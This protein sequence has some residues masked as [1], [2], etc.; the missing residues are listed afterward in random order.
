MAYIKPQIPFLMSESLISNVKIDELKRICEENIAY[1]DEKMQL[2]HNKCINNIVSMIERKSGRAIC[3]I[4]PSV[5]NKLLPIMEYIIYL[6]LDCMHIGT[7][8]PNIRNHNLVKVKNMDV[9]MK[10]VSGDAAEKTDSDEQFDRIRKRMI[11]PVSKF[12]KRI[13]DQTCELEYVLPCDKPQKMVIDFSKLS[14]DDRYDFSEEY[15]Y[16]GLPVMK[17]DNCI[18]METIFD[19]YDHLCEQF[20]AVMDKICK[21]IKNP[22]ALNRIKSGCRMRPVKQNSQFRYTTVDLYSEYVLYNEGTYLRSNDFMVKTISPLEYKLEVNKE[23]RDMYINN[24]KKLNIEIAEQSDKLAKSED[25]MVDEPVNKPV[26]KPVE[27]PIKKPVEKPVKASEKKEKIETNKKYKAVHYIL[28]HKPQNKAK[29]G[30]YYDAYKNELLAD[31]LTKVQFNKIVKL[32]YEDVIVVRS[33][34][35][36]YKIDSESNKKF[37]DPKIIAQKYLELSGGINAL[38]E[39]I[40]KSTIKYKS[41]VADDF[42]NDEIEE[43]V[44]SSIESISSISDISNNS[45]HDKNCDADDYDVDDIQF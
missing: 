4:E 36:K 16:C 30:E 44:A 29:V 27:K 11:G 22:D 8:N 37:N 25:K 38:K 7:N 12:H 35:L 9:Y 34:G 31:A 41:M 18:V 13:V 15:R 33:S 42:S 1:I 2:E 24:L 14:K 26:K 6:D 32:I 5:L 10:I 43:E 39:N 17:L 19:T 21:D 45:S 28:K 20:G 23:F 3:D 40:S